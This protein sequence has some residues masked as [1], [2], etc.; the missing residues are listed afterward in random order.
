MA[1]RNEYNFDHPDAFDFQLMCETLRR[2]RTGKSVEVPVYDFTV[3]RRDKQPKIMYGADVLIVEGILAFHNPEIVDLM[4]IKIFV[5]TDSDT[6]L[7]RRLERD[8]AER[9]RD[10]SGVLQQ[11]IKHVKPAFDSFIA[12]GM[13]QADIIV[14]RGGENE[15]HLLNCI[16]YTMSLQR[17]L[18]KIV[19]RFY[20]WNESKEFGKLQDQQEKTH[21]H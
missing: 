10:M 11:Y 5:D 9:G 1:T 15:V 21:L 4:D 19:I 17:R 2:L 7:A 14:P 18:L 3:H 8:I 20:N 16:E 6:R 13:K 12:P